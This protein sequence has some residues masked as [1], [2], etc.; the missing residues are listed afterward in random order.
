MTNVFESSPL[1]LR[2]LLAVLII[3]LFF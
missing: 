2:I 1:F 3:L